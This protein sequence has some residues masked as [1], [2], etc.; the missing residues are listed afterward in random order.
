[1]DGLL[2]EWETNGV[3]IDG[4]AGPQFIDLPAMGA[5]PKKP[6]IFLHIDWMQD[7]THSHALSA[8]A[9]KKVVD[10]FANA[11][12]VSPTGS[13]GINLHVDQGPTSI[14]NFTTN[15]TWGTLS[16]ARALTHVD[17]L[18]STRREM[19]NA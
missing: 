10:A 15:T 14:L 2:D 16:R 1:G 8:A 3:W 6:D 13:R 4:G 18:G 12:Y 17:N 9:I 5:D 11:P 19:P 7:D